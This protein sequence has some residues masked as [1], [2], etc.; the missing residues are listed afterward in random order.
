MRADGQPQSTPIWFVWDGRDLW[1]RSQP[2][3]PKVAN[4]RAN[5]KVSLHLADHGGGDVMAIEG[6]AE[7]GDEL[8]DGV[9]A[10]YLE[11][12]AEQIRGALGTTPEQLEADY[13][14]TIRIRPTRART[15]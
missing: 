1:L 5:P 12:Y 8:P 15:W 4:V 11:K 14:T 6:E 9:R 13:S 3:A 10:A 7:L 2:K